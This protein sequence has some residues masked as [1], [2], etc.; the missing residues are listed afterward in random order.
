MNGFEKRTQAKRQAI[1]EAA[2]DAF[3]TRGFS[4]VTVEELAK[5]AGVSKV[6]VFKYFKDKPGLA[7]AA[8]MPFVKEWFS[9]HEQ[10]A[11]MEAPFSEK[12]EQI[13]QYKS[14]MREAVGESLWHEVILADK[15]MREIVIELLEEKQARIILQLIKSGKECGAIDANIPD[16]AVELYIDAFVSLYGSGGLLEEDPA[17]NSGL[18]KLFLNGLTG[19]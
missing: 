18:T 4:G 17:I 2:Q 16:K 10:I 3:V 5:A 9:H 14:S 15:A 11:Q 1:L 6:T 7:R 13:F 19:R 12:L 8:L